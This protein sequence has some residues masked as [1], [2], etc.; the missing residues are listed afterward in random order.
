MDQTQPLCVVDTD[1]QLSRIYSVTA[2]MNV[3]SGNIWAEKRLAAEASIM[4]VVC[5]TM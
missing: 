2:E 3:G 5:H 1:T 4:W